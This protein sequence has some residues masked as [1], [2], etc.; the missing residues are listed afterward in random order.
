MVWTSIF[1]IVTLV[2]LAR[3][4][5]FSGRTRL[6]DA[7]K[8]AAI[9]AEA[10]AGFDPAEAAVS[11]DA[12]AALVAARDG[13]LALVRP[14]GDRF[15]VRPLAGAQARLE[16]EVLHLTLAEPGFPDS[17]LQLGPAAAAWA[18]RL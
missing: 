14:F 3:A 13:R 7:G 8:A 12:G 1:G 5:G 9:A 16:G 2:L 4:L 10:L 6:T 17:K 11:E 18:A 15:V